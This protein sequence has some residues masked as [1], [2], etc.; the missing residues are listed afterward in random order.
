MSK[1]TILTYSGLLILSVVVTYSV[2]VI[3]SI[4]AGS[5]IAGSG[6]LPIPFTNGNLFEEPTTDYKSLLLDILFWFGIILLIWKIFFK[7][8]NRK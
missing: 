4:M 2:E 8:T 5:V 3:Q 7:I 6:G 1:K